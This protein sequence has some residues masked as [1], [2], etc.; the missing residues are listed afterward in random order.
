MAGRLGGW[1]G[2]RVGG[3][4]AGWLAGWVGCV[5]GWLG[6]QARRQASRS[7]LAAPLYTADA[8]KVSRLDSAPICNVRQEQRFP[9]AS[10]TLQTGAL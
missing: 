2:V 7:Q 10:A 8:T 4:V 6:L 1:V 3:W 5:A 9:K